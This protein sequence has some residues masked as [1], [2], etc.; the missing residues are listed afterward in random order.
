MNYA[1]SESS[2]QLQFIINSVENKSYITA[3]PT[4]TLSEVRNLIREEWDDHQY[5]PHFNLKVNELLISMKQEVK[6]TVGQI[7]ER[8]WLVELVERPEQVVTN[9]KK[10][11]N[12]SVS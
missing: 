8:G 12:D 7:V 4:Q 6:W 10:T 1:T 3:L 9:S 2:D 5:P 11:A